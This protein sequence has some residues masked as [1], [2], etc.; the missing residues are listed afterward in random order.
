MSTILVCGLDLLGIAV[1]RR[2]VAAGESVRALASADEAANH[3]HELTRLGVPVCVGVAGS[4]GALEAAGIQDASVLILTSDDDA[5]NVDAALAARRVRPELPIVV[6]L[7]EPSLAQYLESTES[8]LRVL[9][10]SGLA[11]PRFAELALQ[12]AKKASAAHAGTP[13]APPAQPRAKPRRRADP[14]LWRLSIVVLAVTALSVLFFVRMLGLNGFDALYLVIETIT[15][16]GYGDFA[17]REA[18]PAAMI[19]IILLMIGGAG[20][21]ALGYALVTGWFLTRR[22][23]IL[24]GRLPHRGRGHAVVAGAGNVGFRVAQRLAASGFTVVVIEQETN[25]RNAAEL[26]AEGHHVIV[27]DAG[28]DESLELAGVD[29]AAVVLAVTDSDAVNLKITFAIGK[30]ALGVPVVIRVISPELSDHLHG[31]EGIATS[32]PVAVAS[33]RFALAALELRAE[34]RG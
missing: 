6:R 22:Q 1:I 30:R 9:S 19:V 5:Q 31:R 11:A 14:V 26:R 29:R 34:A 4:A 12:V 2:L 20:L 7:F 21:L 8:R 10:L 15:N 23:E 28:L 24:E 33:E 3:A 13:A 32:S 18:G 16:T 17:I 27:A 25:S